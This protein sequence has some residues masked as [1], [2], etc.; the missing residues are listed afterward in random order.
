M[1]A[2]RGMSV[3]AYLPA[4]P[5]HCPPPPPV[6]IAAVSGY[7][8]QAAGAMAG[9]S[10]TALVLLLGARDDDAHAPRRTPDALMA[11][12]VTLFGLIGAMVTYSV[13]AGAKPVDGRTAAQEL[14]AGL[15]F[16]L[17]IEMLFFA[18]ALLLEVRPEYAAISAAARWLTVVV[19]PAVGLLFLGIGA[20][21]NEWYR[22]RPMPL[23]QGVRAVPTVCDGSMTVQ[24]AALALV[25]VMVPVLL[26]VRLT[27]WRS[28]WAQAH[29]SLACAGTLVWN[30][31]TIVLFVAVT[32]QPEG[33]VA[34]RAAVIAFMAVAAV[35]LTAVGILTQAGSDDPR[36]TGPG[37]LADATAAAEASVNVRRFRW[38]F[39]LLKGGDRR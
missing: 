16:A 34:P 30:V 9:L 19:V 6:D 4:A 39:V 31:V 25:A 32:L 10:F 2:V 29:R 26:V 8:S 1:I 27:G 17:A 20:R 7:Y 37:P 14:V 3:F 38:G 11:L 13:L 28:R 22:A 18:V 5:A 36:T 35:W 24:M 12:F 23:H 15:S 21:D 33:F